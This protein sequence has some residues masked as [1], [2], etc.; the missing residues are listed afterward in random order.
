MK[1]NVTVPT[2]TSGF[3]QVYAKHLWGK[4]GG[5]SGPG[6]TVL[7][8]QAFTE[9]LVNVTQQYNISSIL[10]AA[11]GDGVWIEPALRNNATQIEYF[12]F[13]I[14]PLATNFFEGRI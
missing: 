2:L 11:C 8:T 1:T 10:D 4:Y 14:S 12:G 3:D 7:S 9:L 13:D 5:G 6:S